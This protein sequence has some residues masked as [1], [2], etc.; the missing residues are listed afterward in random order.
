[1]S[2]SCLI[3]LGKILNRYGKSGQA[4]PVSDFNGISLAFSLLNLSKVWISGQVKLSKMALA[5]F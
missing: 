2:F 5:M 4:C 3:D 1:M